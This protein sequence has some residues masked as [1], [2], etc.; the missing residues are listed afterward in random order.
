MIEKRAVCAVCLRETAHFEQFVSD[1][2]LLP[3]ECPRLMKSF[4][5]A[6]HEDFCAHAACLGVD[7]TEVV[8]KTVT[9]QE[10]FEEKAMDIYVLR[11]E[12]WK[13]HVNQDDRCF[14]CAR[15]GFLS[16]SIRADFNEEKTGKAHLL[17]AISS[18]SLLL[19]N[20]KDH[21]FRLLADSNNSSY[22]KCCFCS[23]E[24]ND[25]GWYCDQDNCGKACHVFCYFHDRKE[26]LLFPS[27]DSNNLDNHAQEENS[28]AK[29]AF[30][31]WFHMSQA[32]ICNIKEDKFL[33]ELSQEDLAETG[34]IRAVQP[35]L[36]QIDISE[37]HIFDKVKE[38]AYP[39]KPEGVV[40]LGE[41]K[42]TFCD[43]HSGFISSYCNCRLS[44]EK[45]DPEEIHSIFCEDC[46]QWFH[47]ACVPFFD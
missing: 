46:G 10:D 32:A 34:Y 19:E 18:P 6:E 30:K 45:S 23:N 47:Q 36:N 20:A 41:R 38:L 8:R 33:T 31:P 14:L 28:Q 7:I 16:A 35:S 27:I 24:V 1:E 11:K 44:K 39:N 25:G 9:I 15:E 3:E 29:P 12:T 13:E 5:F 40:G 26:K 4:V 43:S 37:N 22:G 21:S 42:E 17:C 2:A